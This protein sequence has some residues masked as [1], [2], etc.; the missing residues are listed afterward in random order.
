[1]RTVGKEGIISALLA[2]P[3]LKKITICTGGRARL[4]KAET[5][6]RVPAKE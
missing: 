4:T 5:Y 2:L 6:L 1:M 3:M